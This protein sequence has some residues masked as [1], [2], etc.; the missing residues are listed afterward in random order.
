MNLSPW[1]EQTS[2]FG[3]TVVSFAATQSE[4]KIERTHGPAGRVA[5]I[6]SCLAPA[7]Q[8]FVAFPLDL[9]SN[10]AVVWT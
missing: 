5:S 10:T 4:L 7:Q 2:Y 3:L 1:S 6:W 9:S 8:F